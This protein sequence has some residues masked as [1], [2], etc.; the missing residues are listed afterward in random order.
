MDLFKV[1]LKT[2]RI[3]KYL[4]EIIMLNTELFDAV[5]AL[6]PQVAKIQAEVTDLNNRFNAASA[7]T[8]PEAVAEAI[9]AVQ[10]SVADLDALVPD[11]P[12]A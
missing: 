1:I 11:L 6:A 8:V 3:E 9:A 2:Y 12:A 5:L 10:S 7:G 4:K